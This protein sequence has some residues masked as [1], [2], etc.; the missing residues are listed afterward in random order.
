MD[1]PLLCPVCNSEI[2]FA[3]RDNIVDRGMPK[4]AVIVCAACT[5]VLVPDQTGKALR[6]LPDEEAA[7][8]PYRIVMQI[9]NV[10]AL[11]TMRMLEQQTEAQNAPAPES[12]Q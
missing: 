7:E 5:S 1:K 10:K 9:A 6:E 2:R 3:P 4:G 12:L 11:L 8:L